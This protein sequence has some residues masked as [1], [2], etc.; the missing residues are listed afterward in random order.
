MAY[1]VERIVRSGTSPSNEEIGRKLGV[2][3]QRAKQL[4]DELLERRVIEKTPGSQRNLQVRDVAQCRLIIVARLRELGLIVA[5]P[6]GKLQ[7][8]FT[9]EQLPILPPFEHL[10][11]N[12]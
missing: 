1:I 11:D 6:L 10:P 4:V 3:K 9:Q 12:N 7:Q 8:P 2:S 5:D